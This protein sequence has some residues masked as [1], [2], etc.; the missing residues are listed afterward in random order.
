M[1]ADSTRS[2]M[3]RYFDAMG[4]DQDFSRFFS[5]DVTWSMVDTSEQVSGAAAVRQYIL[6]LHG[7]MSSGEQRPLD[8]TDG[9]AYLEGSAVNGDPGLAYCLVY[10]V[11]D[12]RITAI[13]CY[14]TIA[15][16]V[17]HPPP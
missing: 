15:T 12:D 9:H 10:D 17:P 16:L 14:G 6:E 3:E 11:S 4:H 13:R 5:A 1:S 7:R 8:V 2:V